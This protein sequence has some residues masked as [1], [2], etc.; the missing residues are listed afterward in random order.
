MGDPA[1][2]GPEVVL[3]ALADRSVRELARFVV[4]GR[5]DVLT[6]AADRLGIEPFWFRVPCD[7][8]RALRSITE[9][10]VV[11]D[12]DD[13]ERDAD[14]AGFTRLLSAPRGPAR[15]CGLAS[16]SFV[17]SAIADALR[18]PRDPR[19]V[20]GIVTAPISKKSW[21][22][23]GFSW[24]GHTELLAHRSRAKRCVMAFVSPRLRV[25]LATAHV[26]LMK[27]RDLLTIGRVFDPI[28][29]GHDACRALGIEQPRIAVCGLNPHAGEGGMLGD[30]EERIIAPAIEMARNAGIDARGPFPPD[31][32]FI[33]AAAGRHDLVVSLYHDQGL[34]PLKLLDR[35]RAVNWSL[36]LPII[37]TS[38][39]HGT[40]FDIAPA[41][42]AEPGS[43]IEAIRLAARLAAPATATQR[44]RG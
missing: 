32:V 39:D 13:D 12:H 4:Y 8:D 27:L 35:D 10:V 38:P 42:R 19:R 36:G 41:F 28:D 26:P 9:S 40:A 20:D 6:Y 1:G 17:E 44:E 15:A 21:E 43:M 24:P 14:D 11:L 23:A 5:N 16:K 34:I 3:R 37:R 18:P 25:A 33:D 30:E 29:L 7:S 2:I 31:A 22:L